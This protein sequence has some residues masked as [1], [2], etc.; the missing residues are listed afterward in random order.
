M[1]KI[2]I[3][4]DQPPDQSDDTLHFS[5]P[6]ATAFGKGFVEVTPEDLDDQIQDQLKDMKTQKKGIFQLVLRLKG[7]CE[8]KTIIAFV[9][10][11]A[12]KLPKDTQLV[13]YFDVKK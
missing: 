2:V 6:G 1:A 4:F 11:R 8:I 7:D 10:R 3:S 13:L 9:E 5:N 12:K